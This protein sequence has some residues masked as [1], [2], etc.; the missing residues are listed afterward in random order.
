M[1]TAAK[2]YYENLFRIQDQNPP[3]LAVLLP[4][5][6]KIYE[7]DLTTRTVQAPPFLGV[8]LDHRSEVIYFVVDRYFDYMDLADTIC[9]IY[10]VSAD[11][12][13]HYYPVP[14]YDLITCSTVDEETGK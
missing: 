11:K 14:F 8:S 4:S 3:S 6:E 1:I 2:E 7:V 10:Y 12:K 5:T 9:L 13:S